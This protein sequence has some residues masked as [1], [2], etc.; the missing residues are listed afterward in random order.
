MMHLDWIDPIVARR[1]IVVRGRLLKASNTA[2]RGQH[3]ASRAR[4]AV[5]CILRS[6]SVSQVFDAIKCL[7]LC[8][9]LSREVS[10]W[11]VNIS[12]S[13]VNVNSTLTLT[14][15]PCI[16]LIFLHL[17]Q[18]CNRSIPHEDILLSVAGT[19]LNIVR[20][21]PL[22]ECVQLWWTVPSIGPGSADPSRWVSPALLDRTRPR[23]GRSESLVRVNSAGEDSSIH[24]RVGVT[25]RVARKRDS[26]IGALRGLEPIQTSMVEA[27]VGILLR[28]CRA[29]PGTPGVRLFARVCCVLSILCSSLPTQLVPTG[30]LIPVC[31]QLSD[32]LARRAPDFGYR[33][34]HLNSS[35]ERSINTRP[36]SELLREQVENVNQR[37]FLRTYLRKLL[38]CELDW[39]LY[40]IK[41]RP[42]P[43]VAVDYLLLTLLSKVYES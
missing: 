29:R 36:H 24:S 7:E 22:A 15:G 39:H 13:K 31:E 14:N 17:I 10:Y 23:L 32:C 19:L 20:H 9:R 43:L 35:H 3:L 30:S 1:L 21:R 4:S 26:S 27:L 5:E 2:L 40:P 8:T 12:L 6:K 41:T 33:H 34:L 25:E 11:S 16:H 28:T 37:G 42:D 18:S 38:S